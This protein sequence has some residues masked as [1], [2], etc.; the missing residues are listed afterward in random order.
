MCLMAPARVVGLERDACE[1]V[2]GARRE[3]VST[4]FID[5]QGLAVGDWVLVIG[6]NV[7]RRLHPDQAA[8]MSDAYGIA[9]ERGSSR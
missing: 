2:V 1:V 8:A 5:T 7:A 9:V 4:L 3:R 6:G